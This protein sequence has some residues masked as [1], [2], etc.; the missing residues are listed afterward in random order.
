MLILRL[1]LAVDSRTDVV[2]DSRG[3]VF[4]SEANSF[5]VDCGGLQVVVRSSLAVA[6]L[7]ALEAGWFTE[8]SG[9]N[10]VV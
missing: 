3:L 7:L 8:K 9:L 1:A 6:S 4:L 2:V 5:V 10:T